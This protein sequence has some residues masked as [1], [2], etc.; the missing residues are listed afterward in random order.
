[1]IYNGKRVNILSLS[2]SLAM[3]MIMMEDESDV[4]LMIMV[5]LE[6]M[7]WSWC[8]LSL[9]ELVCLL[10]ITLSTSAAP[11]APSLDISGSQIFKVSK[12]INLSYSKLFLEEAGKGGTYLGKEC[13]DRGRNVDLRNN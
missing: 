10:I 13:G 5:M 8:G 4:M 6:D 9:V 1:M 12:C 3:M 11:A 7:V 2:L